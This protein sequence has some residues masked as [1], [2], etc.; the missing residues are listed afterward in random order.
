M[1]PATSRLGT[2]AAVGLALLIA[3]EPARAVIDFPGETLAKQCHL[4]QAIAVLRVEKVNRDKRGIVYR[5]IHD[6]KG[7]FPSHWKIYGETFTHV[8]RESPSLKF[9][10][11][12][13]DNLDLQNDAIFAWAEEGKMAVIFQRGGEQAICIGHAWYTARSS[14]PEKEH[15]VQ[16][17]GADSRFQR[18]FCGDVDTLVKAVS[19]I[20]AGK[21]VTVPR[22]IGMTKLVSE[23]VGPIRNSRTDKLEPTREFYNPFHWLAAPWGTHRG[24]PQRTGAD[25]SAG[26]KDPKIL[27]VHESSDQ[28]VAPLVP[29]RTE[30][31]AA[32]FGAFNT[33]GLHALALDPDAKQRA[34]W[35]RFTPVLDQPIVAAPA[36]ASMH[37]VV[38][39]FGDGM[40]QSDRA[41][42]RC[43]RSRDGFPLW[44]LPVAGKLVHFEAPV[45]ISG[46]PANR[47]WRVFVGGGS[48]G[49]LGVNPHRLMV[50]GKE[51]DMASATALRE[52]R[53]QALLTKY[54]IDVKKDPMFTV[55]PDESMLPGTTPRLAWQQGQDKWHV[56]APVAV[57]E[58]RLLAA[59]SY[60]DDERIGARAVV[61]LNADDGSVIWKT[62]LK[63]NPWAGPTI[64]PYVLVGCSS[65]RL[66]PNGLE[67]ARGEVVA[68]ELET[69]AVKWRA[70]IPG[71]VLSSIAVR[72]GMA[73]FTTTDGRVRA[74]DA[75]TGQERW[76]YDARAPFFAGPAVTAR[77]IYAADLKGAIHA[78]HLADGKRLWK[79]DLA[80]QAATKTAG[81]VYGAPLIH[82]G[83]LYLAT[84]NLIGD[85]DRKKNVVVCIGD[86]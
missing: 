57:I 64:G 4:A 1:L 70:E 12:D 32:T 50:D 83:R 17:G 67:G 77:T 49:V 25:E 9:H 18:L 47:E 41:S 81:M 55:R 71:G 5:K 73:I 51:H 34:R 42:L 68:L 86:Q 60:L 78:I 62:L 58:D 44:R 80:S 2:L 16:A 36:L 61:C 37:S 66:D 15:W 48:A 59:S 69:G 84:C 38:L 46:T 43:L 21:H 33:P 27:W 7:T 30:L 53:W 82:G 72:E 56:D 22:M 52:Q 24:N 8:L 28:F 11:E 65:T 26:P 10:R 31:F 35:S 23:R 45:T 29:D 20:L 13:H 40:H 14:P 75:H 6:L 3:A 85:T 39:I 76:N 19:E 79:L 63:L 74:L 54:A